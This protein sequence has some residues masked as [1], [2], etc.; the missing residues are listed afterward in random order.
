MAAGCSRTGGR[1]LVWTAPDQPGH[2]LRLEHQVRSTQ[3]F[4]R[5][6]DGTVSIRFDWAPAVQSDEVKVTMVTV[7]ASPYCGLDRWN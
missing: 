2:C 4:F 6:S 3:K 7:V 5:L 1:T